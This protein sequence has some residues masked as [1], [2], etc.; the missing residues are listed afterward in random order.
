[1]VVSD[2]ADGLSS[3]SACVDGGGEWECAR[4]WGRRSKVTDLGCSGE[5]RR[6]AGIWC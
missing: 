4:W 3:L 1:M 2:A 5:V 6:D